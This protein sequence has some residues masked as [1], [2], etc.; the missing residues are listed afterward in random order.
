MA[1][2]IGINYF[3]FSDFQS[4]KSLSVSDF[5]SNILKSNSYSSITYF[6]LVYLKRVPLFWIGDF[7][8]SKVGLG[9]L[10]RASLSE[11]FYGIYWWE[12]LFFFFTGKGY[13]FIDIY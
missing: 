3:A 12:E 9:D 2:E 6:N 13:S 7:G 11:D 4:W 5:V 8:S 10:D 1:F